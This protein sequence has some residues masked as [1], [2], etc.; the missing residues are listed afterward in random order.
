MRILIAGAGATGRYFGARLTQAGR[1]VTFLVHPRRAEQLRDG[2]RLIGPGGEETVPVATVTA[3]A[4]PGI[5]DLVIVAVKAGAL[6]TVMEQV[7][8][9]MGEDT[10]ILPFLNGMAHLTGSMTASGP[11]G[12]WADSLGLSPPWPTTG[13]STSCTRLP[14]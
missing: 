11:T 3:E 14:P 5:Y 8:P 2:L 4:L 13:R 12:C 1:N 9:A 7:A 6:P 10:I